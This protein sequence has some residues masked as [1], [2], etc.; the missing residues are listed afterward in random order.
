MPEKKSAPKV[1]A[2]ADKNE[3][4]IDFSGV[5]PFE[6]LREDLKYL[7]SVSK[8]ERGQGPKGPKYSVEFTIN[9]PSE[10]EVETE[11]GLETIKI[12]GRKLFREYSLTSASLPFLHGLLRALGEK[13]L[14]DNFKMKP[15]NYLGEQV[16]VKIKNEPF[17]EQIRSR[18]QNVLP[19]S[20]YTA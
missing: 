19:A 9:E 20:A 17:E 5:R 1:G 4:S 3:V 13:N 8:M 2:P 7:C 16:T 14:G 12:D 18:V 11:R 10:I 15:S 6:P